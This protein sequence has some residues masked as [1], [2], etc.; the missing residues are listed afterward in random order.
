MVLERVVPDGAMLGDG[1]VVWA[2]PDGLSVQT[3]SDTGE[4]RVYGPVG[5]GTPGPGFAVNDAGADI[6]FVD[7]TY[8]LRRVDAAWAVPSD[9][10]PPVAAD[11][12]PPRLHAM[13]SLER[14]VPVSGPVRVKLAWPFVDDPVAGQRS[15]DLA[16]VDVRYQDQGQ[17]GWVS[18]LWWQG[19]SARDPAT[20]DILQ[21]D[22][23]RC[24]SA[25][26]TDTYGN[27]SDWTAP[28]CQFADAAPP[29]L[30]PEVRLP[31]FVPWTSGRLAYAHSATDAGGVRDYAVGVRVAPPGKVMG[32]WTPST[33][34]G[35]ERGA[36]TSIALS[37][38][39]R[40]YCLR[41]QARDAV[42]HVSGWSAGTC[43]SLATDDRAFERQGRTL[44][45][46]SSLAISG[47]YTQLAARKASI[48]LTGQKGRKVAIWLLRGPGQGMA[49]V[50]AAG[51]RIGRVDGADSTTHKTLR[52]FWAGSFT[53]P[54]KVVQTGTRPVRI[55][56]IAV[57]R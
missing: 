57:A 30:A 1:F 39:G 43:T 37:G 52:S 51:R 8:Q 24:Y 7:T 36:T 32:A 40:Q 20:T 26:G 22:T 54:V 18:P 12:T 6:V 29:V 38:A 55:D 33:A 46:R 16:R 50:Y 14:V 44:R 49:D 3:L 4:T 34:N 28:V 17:S 13:P 31:Q 53:G 41:Y 35:S 10:P 9:L 56:G 23:G 47:T 45:G 19:L 11:T 48:T 25:R 5:Q 15:G 2:S 27:T 42:G 21:P